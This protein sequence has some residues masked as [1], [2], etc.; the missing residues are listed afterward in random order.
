MNMLM[1]KEWDM[2]SYGAFILLLVG[3]VTLGIEGII[4][5]NLISAI[6]GMLGRIVFLA[7]GAA[8]GYIIYLLVLEKKK[9]S[10]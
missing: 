4:G 2:F 10:V 9:N 7:I 3:G 8:A 6:L 5:V 1:I